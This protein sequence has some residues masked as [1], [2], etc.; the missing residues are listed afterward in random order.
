MKVVTWNCNGA[1]RKKLVELDSLTADLYVIQEC[2]DPALSTQN[3]REWAGNYLWVGTSK[4]K[5]IGVFPKNDATVSKLDWYGDFRIEGLKELHSSTVWKTEDLKLF[6]PFKLND[7][8]NLL[9]VWTKGGDDKIFGY[10]GQLW[11]YI[12]VHEKD[13]NRSNTLILG[14]LNSNA[15]W[16]KPDRWWSHSGVVQELKELDFHSLYHAQTG[17]EQGKESTPTFFLHRKKEKP[18]HIDYVFLSGNLLASS[19]MEI[20]ECGKWLQISD[21]VPICLVLKS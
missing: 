7:K 4:N 16:D 13:L 3:Y 20:G 2:E 11:K 19:S 18:Y 10:I 5:G 17:E 6:L 9:G 1:L 15:I 14:D 21:H 12:Q 8:Y